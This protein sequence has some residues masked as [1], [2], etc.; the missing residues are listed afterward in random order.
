MTIY[1]KHANPKGF[2]VYA[3]LRKS[4]NTPYYI[5]KGQAD[6]AW[7]NTIFKYQKMSL[8]LLY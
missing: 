8:K 6:R 4:N 3:Y 2:Y 7:G 1:N 5:G